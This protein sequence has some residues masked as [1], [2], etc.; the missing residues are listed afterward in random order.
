MGLQIATLQNLP[1]NVERNYFVYLLDY[2]W[3]EP[4]TE[5]LDKN[6]NK[7]AQ[8]ASENNAIVIKGTRNHFQDEVLSWHNING[9]DG[10]DI[11]PAILITNRHPKKFQDFYDS[12]RSHRKV[13][14]NLKMIFIPLKKFCKTTSEVYELI[15][16]LFT[17]IQEQKDLKDFRIAK[18]LKKGIGR[19]LADS[20]ILEPNFAGVGLDL[21]TVYDY[22]TTPSSVQIVRE[23][24]TIWD[25]FRRK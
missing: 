24:K 25:C 9:Q 6:Y 3:V 18:E 20:L 11:L 8:I 2:G 22:L 13:E 19:A 1:E 23:K 10:D 16:K 15:S 21:K 17:D 14:S 12:E 5:A 7:M 4:L